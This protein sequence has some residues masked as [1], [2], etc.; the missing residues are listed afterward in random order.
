MKTVSA[1]LI[2]ILFLCFLSCGNADE[3]SDGNGPNETAIPAPVSINVQVINQFPHDTLSFVEGF[4]FYNGKLFESTGAPEQPATN[5]TWVGP[6]DL[7]TGKFEKKVDLGRSIFGEGITFLK[8]RLYQLTYKEGKAFVYD[9]KTFKRIKESNYKG[10]G[11][12]LT[13]DG[14]NL[15]MSTGTSNLY[16]L[17]PDSLKFLRMQ[18]IQDNNGYVNNI[19]ELEYV[20]GYILANQWLTGN[21]LKID[22]A[23]GYVVGRM[24]LSKV[25]NDIKSRYPAAEEMNGIAYDSLSQKTYIT[26]K[27]WPFIYQI[28]W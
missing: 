8:D 9:A 13:N 3:S 27:K 5:G 28:K 2:C 21:I 4:T 14:K 16:Y 25:F 7:K 6:V 22:P 19:N 18:P 15:I 10:E 11:W 12:G 1:V 20:N 17:D 26:G 23:T 24:D